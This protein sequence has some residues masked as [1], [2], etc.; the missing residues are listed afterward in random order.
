VLQRIYE[1]QSLT[2][3]AENVLARDPER[4]RLDALESL[5]SAGIDPTRGRAWR[6][7][8][9]GR[10]GTALT[11]RGCCEVHVIDASAGGFR[12]DSDRSFLLD[13]RIEL[14]LCEPDTSDCYRFPCRVVWTDPLTFH[15]GLALDGPPVLD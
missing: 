3:R 11:V 5:L 8:P 1:F 13:E 14:R 2:L 15:H 9:L 7:D 6:R 4:M 10:Q 12:L